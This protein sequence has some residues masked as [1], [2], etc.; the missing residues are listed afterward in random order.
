M[1]KTNPHYSE[2]F[3]TEVVALFLSEK[4]TYDDVASELGV[5]KTGLQHAG[6]TPHSNSAPVPLETDAMPRSIRR[7]LR[8]T[9]SS[10]GRNKRNDRLKKLTHKG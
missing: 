7:I 5:S 2:Q 1:P 10:R 8:N 9:A 6:S 3:R 4:R